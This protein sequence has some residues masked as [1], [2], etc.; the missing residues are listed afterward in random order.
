[1]DFIVDGPFNRRM[2]R[3]FSVIDAF[4]REI[5]RSNASSAT[6]RFGPLCSFRSRRS[7]CSSRTKAGCLKLGIWRIGQVQGFYASTCFTRTTL[8]I[9]AFAVSPDC[10]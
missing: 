6:I 8:V 5:W 7:S 3:I 4:T 9:G 2:V 1:M 10:K